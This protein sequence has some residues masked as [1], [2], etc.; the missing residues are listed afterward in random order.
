MKLLPSSLQVLKFYSRI[1]PTISPVQG[2]VLNNGSKKYFIMAKSSGHSVLYVTNLTQWLPYNAKQMFKELDYYWETTNLIYSFHIY[3]L[4]TSKV[5]GIVSVLGKQQLIQWGKNPCLRSSMTDDDRKN[6]SGKGNRVGWETESV[7]NYKLWEWQ[8]NDRKIWS[9][10]KTPQ[11]TFS[12][13]FLI[14]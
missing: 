2:S 8:E 9:K 12:A 1:K 7:L 13:I 3:F 6:Y 10:Q 11:L 14:L 5:S 4:S